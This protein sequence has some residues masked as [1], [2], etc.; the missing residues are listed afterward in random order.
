MGMLYFIQVTM[1]IYPY[2]IN[3]DKSQFESYTQKC[4]LVVSV[5]S[6]LKVRAACYGSIYL[7]ETRKIDFF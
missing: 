5:D 7:E 4:S 6:F 3:F 2:Y 1:M